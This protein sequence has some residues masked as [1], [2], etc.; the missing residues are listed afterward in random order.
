MKEGK[1]TTAT[2]EKKTI[3]LEDFEEIIVLLMDVT[4]FEMKDDRLVRF[5]I[6]CILY[7]G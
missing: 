3:R 7:R 1:L 4:S 6:K 5:V 2:R